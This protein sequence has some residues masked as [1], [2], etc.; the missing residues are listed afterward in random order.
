MAAASGVAPLALLLVAATVHALPALLNP[1]ELH[2]DAAIVGLQARHLLQGEWSWF[3]WGSGYQTSTDALLAA[4]LFRV[5]HP[6]PLALMLSAFLGH[7]LLV[8]FV[9]G[10]LRRHFAGWASALLASPLVVT[11][12][13]LHTYMLSPP[14]QASLTLVFCAIWLLDGAP[15]WRHPATA[16]VAGTFVAG[17]ASFADPYALLFLPGLALL[18]VMS[19]ASAPLAA[20]TRWALAGLFGALAGLLPTWLLTHSAQASRGVLGLRLDVVRHNLELLWGTCLPYLLGTTAYYSPRMPLVE[21]WPAPLW[22]RAVQ[23]AGA[24]LLLFGI[25]LGGASVARRAMPAAVRRLAALGAVMLPLTLGA[26]AFSVMV[27]DRLSAR[28]LVAIILMAPFA[29]APLV[30][31]VGPRRLALLLVPF[32]ASVTVAGW[33]NHGDDVAGVRIVQHSEVSSDEAVLARELREHGVRYGLADYW[34][35]YRLT[36]LFEEQTIIVPWHEKL[37]RY[38]PYRSAMTAQP[39]V[40]YIYDPWRSKEGLEEREAEIKANETDFS[41]QFEVLRAGRYTVLLLQRTRDG[42]RRL[43][44]HGSARE[45]G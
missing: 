36:F 44:E 9:F 4:A 43:A 13:P 30:S 40:A 31:W 42:D 26:F 35:A 22:F 2:S 33:L 14:R 10:T 24:G 32:L 38:A 20:R 34:V 29:L 8:C 11:T 18:V 25:A 15:R 19:V 16:V 7:L 27:M 23:L 17:L 6:T 41:R 28:Y 3:L 21:P 5:L 12:G 39:R 37:D 45:P 1:G